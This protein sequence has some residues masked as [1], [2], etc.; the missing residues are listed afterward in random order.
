[1]IIWGGNFVGGIYHLNLD[2]WTLMSRTNVPAYRRYH[3]SN[4]IDG[5]MFIWG[6]RPWSH[7][8]IYN[9]SPDSIYLNSFE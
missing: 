3:S 5:K 2:S 8:G 4:W 6:G 1:M 9:L 7:L